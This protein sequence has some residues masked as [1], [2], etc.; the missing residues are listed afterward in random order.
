M[1]SDVRVSLE[2]FAEKADAVVC[3]RIKAVFAY[4]SAVYDD[5]HVGYSDLDF[6]AVV[7][8][9]L[10]EKDFAVL[11]E[12][13]RELKSGINPYFQI[14]EGAFIPRQ[15]IRSDNPYDAVTWGGSGEKLTNEYSIGGFSLKGL[16]DSGVV[17]RGEDM[18]KEFPYP[19]HEAMCKQIDEL[20][21]TITKHITKT[22]GSVHSIDWL[23]LMCQSAYYLKTG[24]VT[25]K[26]NAAKYAID[27]NLFCCK[28]ELKKAIEIRLNPDIA[29]ETCIKD[30][31]LNLGGVIQETC[32]ELISIRNESA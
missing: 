5:V 8:G 12:F 15:S 13:R 18:R 3:S 30:W 26:T 14:L 4:G 21:E 29:E 1:E 22:S 27:N 24:K 10:S 32:E 20:V 23:F 31:L 6:L 19:T 11:S 17:I 25:C 16:I 2:Q 7:D 9:E 28:P